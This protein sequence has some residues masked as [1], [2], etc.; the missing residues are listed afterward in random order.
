MSP[1]RQLRSAL[2][3]AL[4]L[5]AGCAR[6]LPP[7][8]APIDPEVHRAIDLLT[9]RWRE[10]SDLRTV[11]DIHL[12]RRKE[13]HALTA[14][15]LAKAPASLRLEALSP[16]GQPLLVMTIHDSQL[17]AYN[18]ADHRALIGPATADTAARLLGLPFSPDDLVG[19]LAARAVPPRDLRVASLLP[20]DEHGPSLE[21]I[22]TDHRQR[23]WMDFQS[24]VI[25]RLEITGGRYEA[26][27]TYLRDGDG[28]LRG[29]DLSAANEYLTGSVRYRDPVFD[30]GIDA[31]RFRQTLPPGARV[32]HLR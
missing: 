23:V 32:E 15:V 17:V 22:G 30:G 10:F 11:A 24:G 20:A 25:R 3:L 4:V 2:V 18:A 9:A 26:L 31:E 13:R 14:I 12:Q 8:R 6:A 27:V 1:R 7:L 19:V 16:F 5:L 21:L 28:R 29:F